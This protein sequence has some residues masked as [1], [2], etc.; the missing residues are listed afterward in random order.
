MHAV[1]VAVSDVDP[2][3]SEGEAVLLPGAVDGDGRAQHADRRAE[4]SAG[5]G[6]A[7]RWVGGERVGRHGAGQRGEAA[8]LLHWRTDGRPE[9][10]SRS[11][12][13]S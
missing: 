6:V 7:G 3:G 9:E 1:D 11:G 10:T 12:V 8:V 13:S 5:G 4:V 2:D